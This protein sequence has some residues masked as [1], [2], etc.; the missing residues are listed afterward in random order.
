MVNIKRILID[1]LFNLKK[2]LINNS[3]LHI[4]FILLSLMQKQLLTSG[5]QW[6]FI[7][8]NIMSYFLYID[9]LTTL[10]SFLFGSTAIS[11]LTCLILIDIIEDIHII[12][13]ILDLRCLLTTLMDI[14]EMPIQKHILKQC[15]FIIL[16]LYRS[17]IYNRKTILLIACKLLL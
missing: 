16:H 3:F 14:L 11:A 6:F 7:N 15:L 1:F 9:F 13:D 17:I 2:I 8:L 5:K 10:F 12:I 4:S